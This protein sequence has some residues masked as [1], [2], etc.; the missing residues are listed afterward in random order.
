[1]FKRLNNLYKKGKIDDLALKNAVLKEWI[2]DEEM[3]KII[4]E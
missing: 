3:Q 4:N 2:T 1:M